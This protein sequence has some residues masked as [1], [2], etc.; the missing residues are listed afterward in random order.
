MADIF[1]ITFDKKKQIESNVEAAIKKLGRYQIANGGMAYWP[2]E[3][4]ADDWSTN[5]VGHFMLEAKAKGYALP[6]TF[7][8]NWLRYQKNEARQWRN[9]STRYNS[10]QTQAYRLYTLALAGQ[11]ELAAMN[12]LRESKNLS[13]DAKWRLAAAYALAGKQK[14]AEEISATANVNFRPTNYDYHTYGSP[15]RNKAMALETLVI[16]GN[17]KQRDMAISVAKELSSQRWFSTQE[18]SY[19][20]LAMAK[21]VAKNGGKALEL[22]YTVNGKT[23]TVKSDRAIA[24]R[25]TDIA[26]GSNT[27]SVTNKNNNVVYV[28]L[29]QKGKLPLGNELAERK[30][31][32]V[33]AQYLDGEGKTIDIKNVRQ[34]TEINAVVAI[35]NT[36]NNYVN[37]V[38][39]TK[40]FPGGWEI[41]N[42]SFTELGGGASG[43][44][45]Y[46]DIRDDR[47]NFYFDL[48]AKKTK[49]FTVKLNASYLGTY[50]LPGTQVEA[51]YDNNYYARNQGIWVTIDK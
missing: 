5:Y 45:R 22:T 32:T 33:K 24:Q 4:N 15:F 8:S 44:A 40:I 2:G 41:V 21:M 49:T 29:L 43:A 51:M 23:N 47:V 19:A 11:P 50:Y 46:K 31:L 10:S 12:R 13:N 7:L 30:N 36:S 38:A 42:T 34:G 39:L 20:L 14:V 28:N 35:T 17:A 48:S 1:D 18:T 16:T 26:M 6:I 9:G 25:D 37:H 3:R 27:I